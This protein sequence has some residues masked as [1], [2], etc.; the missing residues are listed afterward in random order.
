MKRA[1]RLALTI[2]ILAVLGAFI[3]KPDPAQGAA[4]LLTSEQLMAHWA[5]ALGGLESLRNV[6]TIHMSGRFK[7]AGIEG[8]V[9][10][11]TTSRG[12]FRIT[13]DSPGVFSQEVVFDGEKGWIVGTS[14]SIQDL[15]GDALKGVITSAYEA[16]DSAFFPG[17]LAGHVGN[18]GKADPQAPYVVRLLPYGGNDLTVYVDGATFLPM[19]EETLSRAGLATISF[20]D[21]KEFAGIRLP[22]TVKQSV[23]NAATDAV[24][25]FDRVE[26]NAPFAAELFSKPEATVAPVHFTGDG[27]RAMIPMQVFDQHVF[28]K[29]R[30][31]GGDPAWFFF[32]TGAEQS[33]VSDV[34]AQKSRLSV[35]GSLL[36]QGAGT[37]VTSMSIAEDAVLSL[38]GL[39]V[40]LKKISVWDFSSYV[41]MIGHAWDGALGYDVINRVVVRVDYEHGRITFFDPATFVPDP[42]ATAFPLTFIGN[43]PVI[44]TKILLPGR[45]PIDAQCA[46]DSGAN[47][48]HLTAP[49][50]NANHVLESMGKTVRSSSVSAGGE[51]VDI[52][53]RIAGLQLG[54]F[55]LR[56]PLVKFSPDLK[57][58]LLSSPLIAAIIGGEILQRFTVT[59]DYPH[60]RV[61][62]EPDAGFSDPFP[63]DASGL[64]F[65]ATGPGF[66]RFEVDD[67]GKGTPADAAGVRKGDV[68]AIIDGRPAGALDLD[69]VNQ[70]LEQAGRTIRLTVERGDKTLDLT[71]ALKGII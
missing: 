39:E 69:S 48:L 52:A 51:Y 29:V 43:I 62:L 42:R 6:R 4:A 67:V 63:V 71:L 14:G 33:F 54:P 34:V 65:L 2:V 40:P 49:F 35:K 47:G 32:D 8:T 22:G 11:W 9:E 12:E 60:H 17:R 26:I 58:G 25:T 20:S 15:S 37:G 27:N 23:G 3:S 66:H 28:F 30:L 13:L 31:N 41:P 24:Y 70:I 21:W 36:A 1:V 57:E 44:P 45:A 56:E 19:K 59:Y 16:S 7:V 50:A 53:G 38:P 46:V 55:L 5:A 68:L 61:F 64:S 10:R 18:L